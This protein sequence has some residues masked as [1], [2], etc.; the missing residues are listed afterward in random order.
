M[1][2]APSLISR[3]QLKEGIL[4]LGVKLH[5]VVFTKWVTTVG[6]VVHPS[7]EGAT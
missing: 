7:L 5:L 3:E 4:K 2:C 1:L 6:A